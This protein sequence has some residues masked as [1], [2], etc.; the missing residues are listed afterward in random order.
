MPFQLFQYP[1]ICRGIE[2]EHD[3]KNGPGGAALDEK[4][5]ADA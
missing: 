1:P 2:A 4:G 3:L 5:P